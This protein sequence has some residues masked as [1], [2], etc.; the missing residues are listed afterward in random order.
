MIPTIP[1][2]TPEACCDSLYAVAAHLLTEVYDALLV[3]YPT[4][5]CQALAAYVT[6]GLGND[7]IPDALTVA[8]TNIDTSPASRPGSFGLWRATYAIILKES[9]WP[10]A[11]VEGDEIVLP[12]PD[13]QAAA[14]AH[15]YAMGEAMH[16]KLSRLYT[17]RNLTP[18]GVGCTNATLGTMF[19]LAPQG[20]VVGWQA[21]VTADLPWN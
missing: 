18:S 14:A 11:H 6:L 21:S 16:R 10:V 13:L 2:D 9:G 15:V 12:S 7:G 5:N 3:C 4:E 17:T 20:G 8:T 19:P 1:C